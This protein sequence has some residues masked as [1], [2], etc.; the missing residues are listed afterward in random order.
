M[1]SRSRRALSSHACAAWLTAMLALSAVPVAAQDPPP[2]P[3]SSPE[4]RLLDFWLGEWNLTWQGGQG[5]NSITRRFGDCVIEENFEGQMPTGVFKG[6]SVSVYDPQLGEW[7]QT[8]VDNQ[9]GFLAFRGGPDEDGVMRLYGEARTLP[10]GNTQITRMS[11]VDVTKDSFDWHWERSLDDG[12]T[13]QMAWQIH[14][15]RA[16]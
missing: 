12:E 2:P 4:A 8:W 6:H 16:E 10:D 1:P 11:W 5:T 14:Y 13:W 7:R 15:E 9:G 3:C